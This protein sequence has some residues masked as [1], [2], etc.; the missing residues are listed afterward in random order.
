MKRTKQH[1][2][3]QP[4]HRDTSSLPP[5]HIVRRPVTNPFRLVPFDP[6]RLLI[7]RALQ[8]P[9][10]Y[11]AGKISKNCWRH[12]IVPHLRDK[13]WN[14]APLQFSTCQ[15]VGPFFISCD[16]GCYHYDG[17]SHGLFGEY[18]CMGVGATRKQA[19]RACLNA[20]DNCDILFA[21]IDAHEC[22]GTVAE[23]QRALDKDVEV[24]IA[25]APGIASQETD[26]FW[27]VS[28]AALRVEYDVLEA[29]LPTL[30]ADILG[31][32]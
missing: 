31:A 20:V 3:H 12:L 8:R 23:I 2:D 26:E 30:L 29:A 11:L 17:A 22:Y 1:H 7:D 18:D 9:K 28:S 32:V 27:F 24:V 5:G 21:Y 16:H 4:I 13:N 19:R 14:D 25:F 15:Y 6:N 10:L